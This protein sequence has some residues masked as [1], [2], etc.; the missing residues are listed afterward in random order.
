MNKL[1]NDDTLSPA[2]KASV[3]I[4]KFGKLGDAIVVT[5]SH[6]CDD[7]VSLI[8]DKTYTALSQTNGKVLDI[9]GTAGEYA[10]ALY[11]KMRALEVSEDVVKNSIY[12]IP[13]S[14]VCY[15]L[16]RKLYEMLGLN[17]A[18]IAKEFVATDLLEVKKDN[19]VDYDKI[20]A[21]LTQN[22]PFDTIKLTDTLTE[23]EDDMI[24][25]EAV[26]G[27][28]PYQ[29]V[30]KGD[31]N[32]AN[33]IY[34]LFIDMGANLSDVSTFIHPSRFLFNAGKTPKDWNKKMLTNS[35]FSVVNY[36]ANST[37]VFPNVDVKGGIAI[38][39]YNKR[40]NHEPIGFFSAYSEL[41]N[42]VNKV[43]ND[44]FAPFSEM[45]YPR[46]LY[47]LTETLYSENPS[48]ENRQ[49]KGHR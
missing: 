10:V 12:T 46:D 18:N 14:S 30:N 9:A 44:R 49:S 4:N 42:I 19:D 15:E 38:T 25:F 1:A 47:H 36:W 3:A 2:E 13:K 7:M 33:P 20:N 40:T 6:I 17:V 39:L 27:N 48:M 8:P 22:K 37:D 16:T 11:K 31:G 23:G 21:L 26:V 35:H 43:I 24:K 34:H 28:P 5:P 41:R 29:T 45:V 32:G